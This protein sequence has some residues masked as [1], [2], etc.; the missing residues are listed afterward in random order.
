MKNT[1]M[2]LNMMKNKVKNELNKKMT[3]QGKDAA[4]PEAIPCLSIS[5]Y[6]TLGFLQLTIMQ[7]NRKLVRF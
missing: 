2:C 1:H 4:E 6:L 3:H 7:K 5:L